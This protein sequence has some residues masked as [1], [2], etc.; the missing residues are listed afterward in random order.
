MS[1]AET[2]KRGIYL[3]AN[4]RSQDHCLNLIYSIRKCGC[5]LPVRVIP[6]G[7]K[8]ILLNGH[9]AGVKCVSLADFPPPALAFVQKLETLMPQCNPGILRRFLCWFGEFD[10]FLYSD[11]D[12]VALMNWENLFP[13]LETYELVNA[14]MEFSTRGRFNLFMPDRFEELLGSGALGA[15]ITAGHFLCRRSARQI[16]DLEAGAEWMQAHPEVVRKHDQS[17]LHVTLALR[18]WPAL[19]LCKPPHCWAST[20]AGDYPN[21]LDLIALIQAAHRPISHLHFSG[22]APAGESAIEELLLS[23]LPPKQRNRKLLQTLVKQPLGFLAAQH[24]AGKVKHKLAAW[25]GFRRAM[26]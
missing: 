22:F 5:S 9:W 25:S 17:L 10:E 2:A 6:Y 26:R 4:K 21:V 20:W 8:P 3:V 15:A 23:R 24:L 12:V 18:K 13:Y 7:G 19:N 14:D 1:K 16:A 11:N